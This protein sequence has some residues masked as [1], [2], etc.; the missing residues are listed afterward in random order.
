VSSNV[1]DYSGIANVGTYHGIKVDV[2]AR[3]CTWTNVDELGNKY[4]SASQEVYSY[5]AKAGSNSEFCSQE[6]GSSITPES[7][8]K[9]T[10]QQSANLDSNLDPYGGT[11]PGGL[12]A[13]LQSMYNTIRTDRG[14]SY[15]HIIADVGVSFW[16]IT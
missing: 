16:E 8:H 12:E 13:V 1:W 6:T 9:A 4:A 14:E 5:T 3:Y 2:W 7:I 15:G 11:P 10:L